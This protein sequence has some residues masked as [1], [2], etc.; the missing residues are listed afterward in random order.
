MFA[1]DTTLYYIGKDIEEV[2]NIMNEAAKELFNW[3]K[4]NQLTVHTG[5]TEAMII[6]HRDVT[7][8]LRPVWFRTS[9]INYVT[10]STCLGITIDNKLSWNKQLSKVTTSFN[11]KLKELRRLRCLPVNVKE[12]TYYKTVVS[13]VTYCI[14][15]CGTSSPTVLQ[16]LD[17]LHAKVAKLVYG[18]KE[19]MSLE[20]TL[21]PS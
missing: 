10:H 14:S 13:S 5:Q 16:E 4:K 7:E 11:S 12:E 21:N 8:P 15:V 18:I 1:D 19:K 2:I 9:V 17:A 6:S 20:N 3:C